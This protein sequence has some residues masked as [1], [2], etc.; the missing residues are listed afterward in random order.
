MNYSAFLKKNLFKNDTKI[1]IIAF[2]IGYTGAGIVNH[3]LKWQGYAFAA[4]VYALI[5]I[6]LNTILYFVVGKKAK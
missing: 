4:I 6:T 3:N 2:Y 1:C 5:L